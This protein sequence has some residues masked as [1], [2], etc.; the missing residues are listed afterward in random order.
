MF[1]DAESLGD[2]K[3]EWKPEFTRGNIHG[4]IL[5]G[6]DSYSTIVA[7]TEKALQKLGNTVKVVTRVSGHVRPGDQHANE[8]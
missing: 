1:K 7:R 2:V 8:Q 5:I 6:G 3:T 4:V